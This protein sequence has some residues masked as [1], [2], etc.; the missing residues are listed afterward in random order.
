[1]ELRQGLGKLDVLVHVHLRGGRAGHK[2]A[3]RHALSPCQVHGHAGG[4]RWTPLR[5]DQDGGARSHCWLGLARLPLLRD[6]IFQK[7]REWGPRFLQRGREAVRLHGCV[8]V[9]AEALGKVHGL[10]GDH[11]HVVWQ[12]G[13]RGQGDLSGGRHRHSWGW[14]WGLLQLRGE[15][16]GLLALGHTRRD[17]LW[18]ACRG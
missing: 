12:W 7:R 13:G 16:L 18:V 17:L 9:L 11:P 2:V 3:Q 15:R 6:L 1:L 8:H 4:S 5:G 10:G 14:G